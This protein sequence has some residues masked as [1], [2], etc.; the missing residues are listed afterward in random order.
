MFTELG[1]SVTEDTDGRMIREKTIL[2]QNASSKSQRPFTRNLRHMRGLFRQDLFFCSG[3][4]YFR[5]FRFYLSPYLLVNADTF[6]YLKPIYKSMANTHV[7][8]FSSQKYLKHTV[9][10][11]MY[12]HTNCQFSFFYHS[13]TN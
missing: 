3:T 4:L 13:H 11:Q 8:H 6:E 9:T 5:V 12:S 1:T 7:K 2:D 10:L